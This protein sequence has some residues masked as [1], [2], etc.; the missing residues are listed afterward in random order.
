MC[1]KAFRKVIECAS[2]RD[3]TG[4][5]TAWKVVD[6]VGEGVPNTPLLFSRSVWRRGDWMTLLDERVEVYHLEVVMEEVDNDLAGDGR[7]QGRD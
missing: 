6:A 2:I 4:N 5:N 3:L 7:G 1:L